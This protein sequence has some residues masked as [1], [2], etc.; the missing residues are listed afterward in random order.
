MTN[1]VLISASHM[2]VERERKGALHPSARARVAGVRAEVV[3]DVSVQKRVGGIRIYRV[4][5]HGTPV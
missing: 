1:T 4:S 2:D 3:G 5:N